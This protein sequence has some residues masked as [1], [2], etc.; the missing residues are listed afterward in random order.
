VPAPMVR[1]IMLDLHTM[2]IAVFSGQEVQKGVNTEKKTHF[3]LKLE[4][5]KATMIEYKHFNPAEKKAQK[6][7]SV[8]MKTG[9][10]QV[11]GIAFYECTRKIVCWYHFILD[12]FGWGWG[13]NKIIYALACITRMIRCFLS[14][15]VCCGGWHMWCV[16]G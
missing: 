3:R 10:I 15:G 1:K 11:K 12:F 4:Q 16:Y 9:F 6:Q 8:V 7:L 13:K 5:R 2:S 14:A